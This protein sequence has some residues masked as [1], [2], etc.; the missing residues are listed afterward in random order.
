[1]EDK[2]L[3]WNAPP[4]T[5]EAEKRKIALERAKA[6]YENLEEFRCDAF[7]YFSLL[8]Y[9]HYKSDAEFK[10]KKDE[11]GEETLLEHP[12]LT[13]NVS[14]SCVETA[15][16][17]IAKMR[18]RVTFLTKNADRERREQARKLDNWVLKTFKK[19]KVW[20][21]SAKAFKSACV[22]GLGILKI[23]PIR[24]KIKEP[25]KVPVVGIKHNQTCLLYTSP[26]PRD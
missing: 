5:D 26:S 14:S 21:E 20:P 15:S 17:K 16:N 2:F 11:Y 12:Y 24:K 10:M 9:K 8:D 25:K 4:K 3:W 13:L 22:C 1:M 7:R 6:L 18:P 19:G 23:M